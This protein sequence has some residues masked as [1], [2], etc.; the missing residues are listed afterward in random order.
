MVDCQ[1]IHDFDTKSENVLFNT[2]EFGNTKL[3]TM[4]IPTKA[5]L[6]NTNEEP[7]IQNLNGVALI[8]IKYK[9]TDALVSNSWIYVYM[10]L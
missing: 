2:R 6:V 1:K 4:S 8:K 9:C 7:L 5:F 10:V 3:M